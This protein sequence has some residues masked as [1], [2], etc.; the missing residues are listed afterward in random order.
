M[1]KRLVVRICHFLVFVRHNNNVPF[2]V[3]L[4]HS[5]GQIAES[6]QLLSSPLLQENIQTAVIIAMC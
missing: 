3:K 2:D 6:V 4:E 5:I 1:Y